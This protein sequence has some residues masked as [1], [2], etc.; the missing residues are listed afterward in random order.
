MSAVLENLSERLNKQSEDVM[1]TNQENAELRGQ[2]AKVSEVLTLSD[3]I[4]SKY[5]AECKR[6]STEADGQVLSECFN[7]AYIRFNWFPAQGVTSTQLPFLCRN[8]SRKVP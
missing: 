2:L 1:A 6:L 3:E 5:E 8:N 7:L 4:R